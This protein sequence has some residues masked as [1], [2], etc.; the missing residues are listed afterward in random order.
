M[1]KRPL[2]EL[3][4]APVVCAGHAGPMMVALHRYVASLVRAFEGGAKRLEIP[5]RDD[6]DQLPLDATS[7]DRTSPA[8]G[9]SCY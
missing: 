3:L 4:A 2:L 8:G 7:D 5:I 6:R 9:E 1:T